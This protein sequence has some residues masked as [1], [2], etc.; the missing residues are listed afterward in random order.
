MNNYFK[1]NGANR[2]AIVLAVLIA[3]AAALSAWFAYDTGARS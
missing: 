2:P 1:A 3:A